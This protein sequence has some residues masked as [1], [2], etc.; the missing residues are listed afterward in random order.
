MLLPASVANQ[1]DANIVE[2]DDNVE[3]KETFSDCE[4]GMLFPIDCV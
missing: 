2:D 4:Q 1:I 3:T